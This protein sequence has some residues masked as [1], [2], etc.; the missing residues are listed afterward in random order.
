MEFLLQ[1]NNSIYLM[2]L[3]ILSFIFLLELVTLF[4]GGL[5]NNLDNLFDVDLDVD[6]LVNLNILEKALHW[7]NVG[8]VPLIFLISIFLGLFSTL[9]FISNSIAFISLIN[10]IKIVGATIIFVLALSFTKL[11]SD[12]ISEKLNIKEAFSKKDLIGKKINLKQVSSDGSFATFQHVCDNVV[13]SFNAKPVNKGDKLSLDKNY[14][15]VSKKNNI[16]FVSE[17][18]F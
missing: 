1:E 3:I 13:E 8:K 4:M 17:V 5:F 2:A 7:L 16:F 9:G 6:G 10:S 11:I 15:V 18:N 12:R 14:I